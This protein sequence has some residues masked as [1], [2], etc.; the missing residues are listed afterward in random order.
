MLLQ[1]FDVGLKSA[2]QH[3]Y[4]YSL[5]LQRGKKRRKK[6]R[7]RKEKKIFRLCQLFEHKKVRR[8][9]QRNKKT[10]R[11]EK[12]DTVLSLEHACSEL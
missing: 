12:K 9:F 11:N 10:V 2:L 4:P 1:K 3:L 8:L 6:K 7:N 5:R